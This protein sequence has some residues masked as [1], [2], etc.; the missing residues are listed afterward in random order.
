[1]PV[2][3][4]DILLDEVHVAP[5]HLHRPVS[6]NGLQADRISAGAQ[7]VRGEGMP[8]RVRANPDVGDLRLL[9]VGFQDPFDPPIVQG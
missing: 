5:D 4:P 9:S 6:Q 3:E 7:V 8:Q 2:P 1:M